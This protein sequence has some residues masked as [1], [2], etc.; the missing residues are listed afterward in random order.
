MIPVSCHTNLD[1][2]NERWP[3]ELPCRP[4]VGDLIESATE[5]SGKFRLSLKVVAV[6]FEYS[7]I[8]Q[9]WICRV[10]LHSRGGFKV[11]QSPSSTTGTHR[12]LVQLRE[13]S[14]DLRRNR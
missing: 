10:E 13:R 11:N 1:L 7:K 5:W 4:M 9:R 2:R 8:P 3:D 6:R 12:V 14:Y